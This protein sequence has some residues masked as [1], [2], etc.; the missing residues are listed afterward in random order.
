MKKLIVL[1]VA[2][3]ISVTAGT[4]FGQDQITVDEFGKGVSSVFG[5]LPAGPALDPLSGMVTLTY[6]LPF[7]GTA[8]DVW[9]VETPGGT[10]GTNELLR[11]DG[12]GR[13][14]FFSLAEDP[15]DT[16]PADVPVMPPFLFG[17]NMRVFLET[18]PEGNNGLFG[19]L[20][21]PGDPGFDIDSTGLTPKYDFISDLA[22]PEPASAALMGF[23]LLTCV[24]IRRNRRQA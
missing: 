10:P 9:L 24:M 12:A 14:F 1:A 5:G 17:N 11:F 19:Y 16:A 13:L 3:F 21:N 15:D 22:V 6:Q 2:G 8:G 4:A 23:G 20:P 18:G 7:A